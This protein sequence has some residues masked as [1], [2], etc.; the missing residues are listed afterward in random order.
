MWSENYEIPSTYMSLS[1]AQSSQSH[2]LKELMRLEFTDPVLSQIS[3][4]RYLLMTAEEIS[5]L[6]ETY[7]KKEYD[8]A[9]N[10]ESL[11]KD[12]YLKLQ[13][14]LRHSG[15]INL[16]HGTTYMLPRVTGKSHLQ[17]LIGSCSWSMEDLTKALIFVVNNQEWEVRCALLSAPIAPSMGM[18]AQS[19]H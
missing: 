4:I 5:A 16:L 10:I 13:N 18:K 14:F 17:R 12:L 3:P 2:Q 11:H 1:E 15:L 8:A 7:R 6:Y 19:L 9:I